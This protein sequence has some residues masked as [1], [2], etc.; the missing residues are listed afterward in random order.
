VT[1]APDLAEVA[2]RF[3]ALLSAAGV[4]IAPERCGRFTAALVLAAPATKIELYWVARVTLLSD[5]A[6]IAAFD[7][8]FDRVF[9]A[10][11]LVDDV[12]RNPDA[13]PP[14]VETRPGDPGPAQHGGTAAS[15]YQERLTPGQATAPCDDVDD[16]DRPSGL[17]AVSAQERLRHTDF[18]ALSEEELATVS[19]LLA[20]VALVAPPR[21]ARRRERHRGG[22]HVDLRATLARAQRTGGDPVTL[23]ER[24]RRTRSRRLVALCDISGSMEPYTRAYLQLLHAAVRGADAEAFVFAT[25]LTRLTRELAVRTPAEALRR[26]GKAAPDW[27]GGT[28]I[29]R[30]L[31]AFTDTYGRRGLARG[32]VLLIVSDGWER[33]D[34]E[35]VG[36]QMERLAR[37]AHRIVWVNPRRASPRYAPLVA[38]MAAALPYIDHFVSGHSVAA[39]DEVRA[40]ISHAGG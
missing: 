34:P 40:A 36:T 26:A 23:V 22:P 29:G 4:P 7:A 37:L 39:L 12:T 28:R 16:D 32:A 25:R 13:P 27:S 5:H 30:A 8:V 3:G 31:K 11:A 15:G 21:P 14:V 20:R 1:A 24:R 35:L 17:A 38:G 19:A 33:D 18:A 10:R 2:V 9:G 6:H